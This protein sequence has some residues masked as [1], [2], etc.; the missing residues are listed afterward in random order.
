MSSLM[1][2]FLLDGCKKIYETK[3]MLETGRVVNDTALRY[4][5][6]DES[7]NSAL[8]KPRRRIYEVKEHTLTVRDRWLPLE[9]LMV[10]APVLQE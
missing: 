5:T 10:V 2:S 3:V 6:Q 8:T 4:E 1:L 9:T 7:N